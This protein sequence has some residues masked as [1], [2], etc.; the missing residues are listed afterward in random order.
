MLR[1]VVEGQ[2]PHEVIEVILSENS[3]INALKLTVQING[4]LKCP[5]LASAEKTT[6]QVVNGELAFPA[7]VEIIENPPNFVGL[8]LV[9]L[10]LQVVH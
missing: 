2:E 9:N 8:G 3:V 10:P 4:S 7:V 6:E 1:G 5:Y